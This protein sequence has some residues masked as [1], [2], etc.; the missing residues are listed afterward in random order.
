MPFHGFRDARTERVHRY[1]SPD[2][3]RA[4]R[5][6]LGEEYARTYRKEIQTLAEDRARARALRSIQNAIEYATFWADVREE[7]TDPDRPAITCGVCVHDAS[8]AAVF[9]CAECAEDESEPQRVD[10]LH[11]GAP[12][13][14]SVAQY[15]LAL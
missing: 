11:D 5:V 15:A 4:Q 2:A 6:L 9:V 1:T 12:L 7:A 13:F 8:G 3:I 10:I 14:A